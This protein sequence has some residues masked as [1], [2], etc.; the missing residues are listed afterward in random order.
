M[1]FIRL[2]KTL[3]GS[4]SWW[5][6]KSHLNSLNT[7]QL[8][9][10]SDVIDEKEVGAFIQALRNQYQFL[11]PVHK[12]RLIKAFTHPLDTLGEGRQEVMELLLEL[13]DAPFYLTGQQTNN[14]A[15]SPSDYLVYQR[16]SNHFKSKGFYKKFLFAKIDFLSLNP[17]MFREKPGFID[18][19][20]VLYELYSEDFGEQNLK[21][22]ISIVKGNLF[23][24]ERTS[25]LKS[26]C[27]LSLLKSAKKI[28]L[29]DKILQQAKTHVRS[30][31]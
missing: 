2:R 23:L 27:W 12:V 7:H 21:E 18:A 15:C 3:R 25:F 29:N 30:L 17:Q 31:L 1:D 22:F 26:L 24:M 28:D 6:I 19:L 14:V 9:E 10:L 16:S 5:Q 13:D 4:S 20:L 11:Q 8:V